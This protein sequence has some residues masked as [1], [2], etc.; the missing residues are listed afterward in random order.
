ML[1]ITCMYKGL[2]Q[3]SVNVVSNEKKKCSLDFHVIPSFIVGND[4][5]CNILYQKCL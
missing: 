3:I 1:T 5:G 4:K 2:Y